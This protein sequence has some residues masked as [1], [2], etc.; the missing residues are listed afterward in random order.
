[1]LSKEFTSGPF[2][3]EVV[4]LWEQQEEDLRQ[5]ILK[6]PELFEELTDYKN[7]QA[8]LLLHKTDEPVIGK[9]Y[10]F[11]SV[12]SM[13]PSHILSVAAFTQPYKL[14]QIENSY[15]YFEINGKIK[16]YPEG[17]SLNG[18]LLRSTFM[19]QQV[20]EATQFETLLNLKFSDWTIIRREIK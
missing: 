8:F 1:M 10:V 4:N 2:E 5:E 13:M 14:M 17:E 6:T 9:S 16:Q 11:L 15:A 7:L 18:D 12:I 19:F 20:G 3:Y